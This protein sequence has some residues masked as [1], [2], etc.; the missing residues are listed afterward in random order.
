MNRRCAAAAFIAALMLNPSAHA[1]DAERAR[2]ATERATAEA[3][4]AQRE[5]EC[6]TRFVVTACVEEARTAYRATIA[7]LRREQA[8]L[9]ET[10][11]RQR[12]A[13]RQQRLSAKEDAAVP[14]TPRAPRVA[15]A[16][17]P[18]LQADDA[19]SAPAPAARPDD[20]KS[21]EAARAAAYA[22]RIEAAQAHR[23]AVERRNAEREKKGKKAQ[24]LPLPAS[25]TTP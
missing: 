3:T 6:S 14:P 23:A 18:L 21:E 4:L 8:V 24:P 5:R 7:S 11:R 13:E 9:D 25:A 10:E 20:K 12:A 1:V 16:A 15:R 17:R 22:A 19:A 2:I